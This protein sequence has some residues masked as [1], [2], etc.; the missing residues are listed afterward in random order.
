MKTPFFPRLAWTGI[1]KNRKLYI[2]YIL[3]CIGMVMM[4]YILDGLSTSP[5]LRDMPG[6][7]DMQLVLSLGRYVIAAFALIFLFYTNSFLIRRRFREFGLYNILGMDK[8]GI[9]GVIVWESL[10]VAGIG[11]GGGLLCGVLL[12]KLAELGLLNVIH[13]DVDFGFA[14]A[15]EAIVRTTLIFAAIF[16]LLFL[17]SLWQVWRTRPME[18]LRSENFGEKPP[19]ANRVFAVLGLLI[20][21]GAYYF[22]VSIESPL[23]AMLL[24]FVAVIMVIAATY[25]LFISGSVA[26]CRILQRDKRYYYHKN[27]F[28][29]VSSMAF[30]MKRNGAGLASICIL[31][32]MVLVMI[33]STSSLYFGV[34]EMLR[35]RFPRENEISIRIPRLDDLTEEHTDTVVQTFRQVLEDHQ[36]TPTVEAHY[37]FASI[38]VLEHGDTYEPDVENMQYAVTGFDDVRVLHFMAAADYNRIMGTSLTPQ[39]GQ[40]YLQDDGCDAPTLN[41]AGLHLE[42]VGKLTEGPAIDESNDALIPSSL[43]VI[44]DLAVLCPLEDLEDIDG[45]RML[46]IRVYY[47]CDLAGDETTVYSAFREMCIAIDDMDFIDDGSGYAY[48]AGCKLAERSGFY[49]TYG[50]LFFIGI[51]LSIVF[52]FAAAMIIYYKQVSEG[53]EDQSRFEIMQKVGMTGHDIRRSINSQILMVFFAPLLFAGLHLGFAFP[54]I[55]KILQLFALH[56]LALVLSVTAGAFV[57]FGLFYACIYKVTARAYYGIVSSMEQ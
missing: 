54:L 27:H 18:L 26:L 45:D 16:L 44:S 1:R 47:G 22:A 3:S 53:Y 23:A 56:E 41:I 30:R 10:I 13:A 15:P 57:L 37:Y 40:A 17:R 43:L 49:H 34:E 31:A 52:V 4:Y 8:C 50:G 9:C 5:L 12:Y 51:A 25:L 7:G 29:S 19:Q 38:A 28:V 21:S 20:L 46:D 6:G 55:W 11:L 2:P 36:L 48:N 14:L 35:D 32:T 39:P 33:S 42:V 24:F